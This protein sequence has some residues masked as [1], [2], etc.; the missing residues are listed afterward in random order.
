M[1]KFRF[2]TRADKGALLL[3]LQGVLDGSSAWELR[4]LLEEE[5]PGEAILDF[6]GIVEAWDF[7]AA[8]LCAGLRELR[9]PR[10]RLLEPPREVREWM[11][12][13]AVAAEIARPIEQLGMQ[14]GRLPL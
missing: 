6:G 11:D 2:E 1:S 3:R 9:I 8:V 4:H 5:K 7:G 13:F 14:R 12:R 10:L